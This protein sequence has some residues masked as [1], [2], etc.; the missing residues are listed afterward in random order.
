[1]LCDFSTIQIALYLNHLCKSDPPPYM[2]LMP[3]S[4]EGGG[5]SSSSVNAQRP[6]RQRNQTECLFCITQRPSCPL[7][8]HPAAGLRSRGDESDQSD[9]SAQITVIPEVRR[10]ATGHS[11]FMQPAQALDKSVQ[12]WRTCARPEWKSLRLSSPPPHRF[13]YDF[14]FVFSHI[15]NHQPSRNGHI[16]SSMVKH[17]K[18][19]PETRI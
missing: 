11:E 1:M 18:K 5:L 7:P 2:M 19:L 14:F 9:Q 3:V 6:Q 13:I 17:T 10:R 8:P 4:R 12:E 16:T 15:F